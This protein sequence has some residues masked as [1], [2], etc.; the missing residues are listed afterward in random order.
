MMHQ[1]VG[2]GSVAESKRK[3]SNCRA[4]VEYFLELAQTDL[5]R[6]SEF[7]MYIVHTDILAARTLHSFHLQETNSPYRL[8]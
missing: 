5:R 2:R 8:D 6:D 1:V 7:T 3:M 4:K